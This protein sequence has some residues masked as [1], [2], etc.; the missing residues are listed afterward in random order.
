MLCTAH[1]ANNTDDPERLRCLIDGLD[2]VS[3]T[4]PV[5]LPVHPRTRLRMEAAGI[6]AKSPALK[7][8][9]PIG[10]LDM[11]RLEL[12]AGVIVT[13]SGG[14]QREAF[15][16]RRP[17]VTFRDET[18]WVELVDLGWNVLAPL[19]S[20][21]RFASLVLSRLDV[22]GAEAAPYGHGDAGVRI[23]EVLLG[24]REMTFKR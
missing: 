21:T 16:H 18:E 15:F 6:R 9:E 11:V 23:A 13:D 1:R 20:A 5:I 14:V 3:R 10:Y 24:V 22:A 4:L 19:D 12:E 8:V 2:I 7:L 17:C